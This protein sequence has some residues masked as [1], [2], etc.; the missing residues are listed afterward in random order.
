MALKAFV[1]VYIMPC[2]YKEGVTVTQLPDGSEM[3]IRVRKEDVEHVKKLAAMDGIFILENPEEIYQ[4]FQK[5]FKVEAKKSNKNYSLLISAGL[6]VH[7]SER[8][9]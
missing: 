1:P 6:H 3:K 4:V 7:L 5:H 8:M 2:D 9:R